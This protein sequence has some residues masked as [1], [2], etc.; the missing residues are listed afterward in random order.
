MAE[1]VTTGPTRA[2]I[3]INVEPTATG[4]V[5]ERLRDISGAHVQ[6]VLGPYDMVIEVETEGSEYLTRLL[7]EKI[8][9]IQGVLSTVTLI[10]M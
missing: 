8:R 7:R 10:W 2:Y 1:H 3:L 4:K 6:E 9:P 5:L